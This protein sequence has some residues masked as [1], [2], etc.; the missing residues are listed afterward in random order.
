MKTRRGGRIK[1]GV[2]HDRR[3]GTC[4][5]ESTLREK[6]KNHLPV[7]LG[8][9]CTKQEILNR[10]G[11]ECCFPRVLLEVGM[12]ENQRQFYNIGGVRGII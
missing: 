3:I 10:F 12:R 4:G 5:G 11:G 7:R 1:K 9:L 6:D 2:L 8:R